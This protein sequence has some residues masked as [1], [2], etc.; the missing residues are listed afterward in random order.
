MKEGFGHPGGAEILIEN[1]N[2]KDAFQEYE[3]A[4]HTKRAREMLTAHYIGYIGD[5]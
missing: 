5:V 1:S 4:D 3:D 2:G